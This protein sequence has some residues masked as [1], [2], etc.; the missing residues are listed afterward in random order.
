[1]RPRNRDVVWTKSIPRVVGRAGSAVSYPD[2][3]VVV[4]G[5]RRRPVERVRGAPVPSDRPRRAIVNPELVRVGAGAAARARGPRDGGASWQRKQ[6]IGGK[7]RD[8]QRRRTS[9]HE[10]TCRT[11]RIERSDRACVADPDLEVVCACDGGRP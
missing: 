10:G 11:P 3:E 7:T 9:D 5:K 1:Q 8:P 4:G 6:L 2:L